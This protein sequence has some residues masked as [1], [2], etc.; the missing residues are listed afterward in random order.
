MDKSETKSPKGVL[1]AKTQ[2]RHKGALVYLTY[3]SITCHLLL[4][5][6]SL[7]K[8]IIIAVLFCCTVLQT[9]TAQKIQGIVVDNENGEPLPAVSITNTTQRQTTLSDP[10]GKYSIVCNKDDEIKFSYVGY[11]PVTVTV[12]DDSIVYRKIELQRKLFSLETV[13]IRPDWTPYQIDSMKRRSIYELDL[14][15]NRVS[16]SVLGSVLSPASAL[17]E[18]FSKKSKQRFRFQK[19]FAKWESQRFV[20]T[21]YTSEEVARLTGLSGDTLAVFM[22][23]HPMPYDFARAATDLE[24]KMWIRYNYREWIKKPIVIPTIPA[25]DSL[26]NSDD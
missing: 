24:I 5:I 1:L 21:R 12:P 20:D 4:I 13:N 16:S 19:N 8:Y 9:A 10:D 15:R 14:N 23:E 6:M 22:N 26:R 3:E 11:Y 25:E 18:Q 17:A 2:R 7:S